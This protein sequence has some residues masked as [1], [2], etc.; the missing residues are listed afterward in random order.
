MVF[1]GR[2]KACLH[3]VQVVVSPDEETVGVAVAMACTALHDA[4]AAGAATNS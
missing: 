2:R 1:E 4:G 3:H